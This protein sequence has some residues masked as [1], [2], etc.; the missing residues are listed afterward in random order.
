MKKEK[1]RIYKN[2]RTRFHPSIHVKINLD[3]KWENIEI[4]SSPTK[5]GKYIKFEINPNKNTPEKNV[6]FRKYIRK[7]PLSAR[8]EEYTNYEI[9]DA[10][11]RNIDKF[12]LEHERNKKV[13]NYTDRDAKRL[14]R[15]GN[16][17]NHHINGQTSRSFIKTKRKRK[18]KKKH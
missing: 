16:Q 7:D 2:K 6:W 1:Y 9:G 13:G 18:H 12:L 4:T 14:N 10:D 5:T 15:N 17:A 3:N 11:S 8:G